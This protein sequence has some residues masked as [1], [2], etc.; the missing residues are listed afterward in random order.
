MEKRNKI[1]FFSPHFDDAIFSC[2]GSIINHIKYGDQVYVVTVFSAIP[3]EE[4]FNKFS[5]QIATRELFEKRRKENSEI[6]ENINVKVVNFDYL[7]AIFRKNDLGGY[8]CSFWSDVFHFSRN[9]HKEEK[10]LCDLLEK[11]ISELIKENPR[12]IYLPLSLGNHIDHVMVNYI[13]QKIGN[14]DHEFDIYYYEDLPYA[15]EYLEGSDWLAN[16]LEARTEN[17]DISK[18]LSLVSAYKNSLEIGDDG[19]L[20]IESIKNYAHKISTED[21]PHER[22]WIIKK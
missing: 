15:S 13:G 3:E 2:G 8:L 14:N 1:I 18:K 21:G 5:S 6:L 10:V 16:Y 17:I 11:R 9:K 7:D 4:N 12:I 20:T 19:L 22:F